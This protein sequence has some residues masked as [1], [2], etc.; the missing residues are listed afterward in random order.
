MKPAFIITNQNITVFLDKPYT[1][2]TTHPMHKEIQEALVSGKGTCESIKE[3]ID[4]RFCIATYGKG[5]I[6]VY[7]DHIEDKNGRV[8]H[9]SLVE[10]IIKLARDKQP[11]EYLIKFLDN[12]YEN[13][14]R[15]S[16]D[17]LYLFLEDNK[18][19]IT[20]DGCFLAY[21]GVAKDYKDCWTGK[22]DNSVGQV[23]SM[24]RND[25]DDDR[26]RCCSYGFHC[27]R[28]E[29]AADYKPHDGHLM[30]VK[31][32]PADVVSVPYDY[33]NA[34]CRVCKY[35]VVGEVEEDTLARMSV[36]DPE[37]LLD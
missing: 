4:L 5:N 16:V 19:P 33:G 29:Y 37:D 27:G 6:K 7:A 10:R 22:Y 35:E 18:L 13:P 1:V 17:E 32:D 25:V 12:L 15:S 28:Y 14:S 36:A 11:V 2:P 9:G 3:L 26:Q 23:L 34:K 8:L 31:V 30:V 21:K 24:P 20:P